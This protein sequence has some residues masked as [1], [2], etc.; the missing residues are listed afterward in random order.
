MDL[1][2]HL[3]TEINQRDFIASLWVIWGEELLTLLAFG[4]IKIKKDQV[5]LNIQ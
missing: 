3:S 2:Y 5:Y 1:L 4:S